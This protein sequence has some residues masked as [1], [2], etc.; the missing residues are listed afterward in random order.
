[1]KKFVILFLTMTFILLLCNQNGNTI[2]EAVYDKETIQIGEI[3]EMAYDSWDKVL[4]SDRFVI[5]CDITEKLPAISTLGHKLENYTAKQ[6]RAIANSLVTP[7]NAKI[8]D[9]FYAID[10]IPDEI[11]ICQPY[12]EYGNYIYTYPELVPLKQGSSYILILYKIYIDE[13]PVYCLS[14]V[15]QGFAEIIKYNEKT[16]KVTLSHAEYG[17]LFK[18]ITSLNQLKENIDNAKKVPE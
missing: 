3:C 12:G 6:V 13:E 9:V 11:T 14:S 15:S 7:Y 5:K 18:D 1:M 16:T 17:E 8:T 4:H 10:E 2:Q